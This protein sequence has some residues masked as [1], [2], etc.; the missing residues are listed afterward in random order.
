MLGSVGENEAL[1][2]RGDS[3]DSLAKESGATTL[4]RVP[5]ASPI[6]ELS[7]FIS[8]SENVP[9]NQPTWAANDA[10]KGHAIERYPGESQK[11]CKS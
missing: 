10:E 11:L 7:S 1:L 5:A 8:L 2:K 9:L 3:L 4:G 6:N